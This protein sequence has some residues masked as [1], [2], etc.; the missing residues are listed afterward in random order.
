[1]NYDCYFATGKTHKVCEDFATA[2]PDLAAVADGCSSS[3]D[4]S[5]GARFV[6]QSADL[7]AE[8]NDDWAE[9]GT[10]IIDEAERMRIACH[11]FND[12]LDA[13][14]L[15]IVPGDEPHVRIWGDGVV[16]MRYR[17][18]GEYLVHAIEYAGNAPAYPSY[19]LNDDRL[20]VYMRSTAAKR[21]FKVTYPSGTEVG[22]LTGFPFDG[23]VL[24]I[25]VDLFDLVLV[26][27]DGVQSFQAKVGRKTVPVALK[28]VLDQ[29]SFHGQGE[30]VTR[31]MRWFL[32]KFCPANGWAHLDDLGVAGMLFEPKEVK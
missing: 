16:V 13:T 24:P 10:V 6:C 31:T 26:F 12:C 14:L 25:N 3:S 17:E 1:M 21:T 30:F 7:F 18:T 11:L 28:D 5:W 22:E 9:S 19:L 2:T 23:D 8:E 20:A 29:L 32:T 27:T 4:T 15:A